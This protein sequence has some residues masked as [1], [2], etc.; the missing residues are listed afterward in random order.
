MRLLWILL[1]FGLSQAQT[2]H[3][4][5]SANGYLK[6]EPEIRLKNF[7]LRDTKIDLR[8]AYQKAI[9][10]GVTMRQSTS[11]GPVGNISL[12][13]QADVSS[14]GDYHLSLNAD[15]VIASGGR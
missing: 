11:F 15:G 12:E 6:I 4:A 3:F 8:L 5:V 1:C 13:G 9:E 2:L 7:E 10:F 14:A